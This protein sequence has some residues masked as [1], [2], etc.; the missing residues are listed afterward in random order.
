MSMEIQSAIILGTLLILVA[1]GAEIFVAMAIAGAIG[2]VFFVGQPL[3]QFAWSAFAFM[4]SFTLTAMP[5]FILM[6]AIF[7]ETGVV[8]TLFKG[9]NKILG[10]MPG[11]LAVSVLGANA[12]FGAVSGS[13]VAASATFGKICFPQMVK[14]G[15][16]P[17][18]S[19]GVLA[20]GGTLAVLIPPSITMIVYGG[21]ERISVARLFAG[22]VVPGIVLTILL[23]ITVLILVKVNPALAPA[24]PKVSWS[25]RVSAIKEVW[26][27]VLVIVIVLGVIFGGIMTPTESAALGVLLSLILAMGYRKLSF[28]ALK[29]SMWLAVKVN[30]MIALVIV[31]AKVIGIVF[32]HIGITETFSGYMTHLPFGKYGIWFIVVLLYLFLG[33]LFDSISMLLLT[34]PFISPLMADLGFDPTWFGVT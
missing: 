13:T 10:A 6:G 17:K 9:V 2:L 12:I 30:G 5:L 7:S 24:P 14:L 18:L 16:D 33:C 19:L 4:N 29:D 20:M 27:F 1:L 22:G 23:I 15:Y 34:L 21:W 31:S 25:V 28:R 11:G 26:P 8:D 32:Q 3:Q